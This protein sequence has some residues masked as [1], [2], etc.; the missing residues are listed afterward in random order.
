MIKVTVRNSLGA[1][2]EFI[3]PDHIIRIV[4]R[5]IRK[6]S[7]SPLRQDGCFITITQL[8][9]GESGGSYS[10]TLVVAEMADDI[11]RKRMRQRR[12]GL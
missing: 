8:S 1:P 11:H 5:M 3:N 4:P 10:E 2:Y 6:D 12:L 9:I 7:A